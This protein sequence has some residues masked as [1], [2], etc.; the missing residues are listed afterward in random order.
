MKTSRRHDIW[1][2]MERRKWMPKVLL[3]SNELKGTFSRCV[4]LERS[5]NLKWLVS[6]GVLSDQRTAISKPLV[7]YRSLLHF[8]TC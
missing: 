6:D 4:R 3:K 2:F 5:Y 7:N 8:F 1:F